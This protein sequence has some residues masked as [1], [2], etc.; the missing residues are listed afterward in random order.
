MKCEDFETLRSTHEP[1]MIEA[2]LLA[3]GK[4]NRKDHRQTGDIHDRW[5][6]GRG[7]GRYGPRFGFSYVAANHRYRPDYH[8]LD[9]LPHTKCS[10]R[11]SEAMQVKFDE[12]IRAMHGAHKA[13]LDLEELEEEDSTESKHAMKISP[14]RRDRVEVAK[15]VHSPRLAIKS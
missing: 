6:G 5:F 11:D 15:L 1:N 2:L 3:L 10:N 8:F 4:I 13:L 7:M 14:S 9:G 12:L